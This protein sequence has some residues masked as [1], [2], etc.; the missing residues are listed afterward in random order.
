MGGMAVKVFMNVNSR[1]IVLNWIYPEQRDVT[2]SSMLFVD[3]WNNVAQESRA[4][5]VYVRG[6][7]YAQTDFTT[8]ARGES[9]ELWS[10]SSAR[11]SKSRGC[12]SKNVAARHRSFGFTARAVVLTGVLAAREVEDLDDVVHALHLLGVWECVRKPQ[13]RLVLQNCDAMQTHDAVN[14]DRF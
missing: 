6:R 14:G 2:R 8:A 13:P 7:V 4:T 11:D 12:E 3:R 9:S 10:E 1:K 5:A